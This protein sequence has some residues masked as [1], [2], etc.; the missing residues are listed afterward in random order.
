[1]PLLL[2]VSAA[3]VAALAASA[4]PQTSTVS[5]PVF[6]TATRLIQVSVVVHD[7]RKQ[8][9]SGLRAEDFQIFEDGKEQSVAFFM[10]NTKSTPTMAAEKGLFTNRVQSPS[11]GGVVAIVYDQLNTAQ[12]DQERVRE[13]LIK[14]LAKVNPDD[15][16]GLYVLNSNGL[17]ILH[18]FTRDARSLLRILGGVQNPSSVARDAANEPGA[19]IVGFGDAIDRQLEAFVRTGEANM[20]GFFQRQLALRSIDAMEA[21][22]THLAGVP[23]R[24]NLIW[25]SSGFPFQFRAYGPGTAV[26][27][28]SH[29][30]ARAARALNDADVAV[31]GVDARGLVGAFASPPG[32]RQ[33]TFTTMGTVLGPIEGLR[34][35]AQLTGGEAYFNS[36]DLG[37]AI[38]RAVDDSRLTY[39][40]GYYSEHARWDGRFRGISVKV[41]RNGV[42]V[43]HRAGYYAIPPGSIDK[44]PPRTAAIEDALGSPLETTGLSISVSAQS[45][46]AGRVTLAIQF[47]PGTPL[48]EPRGK[49]W[50]GAVDIAIA[51]SLPTRKQTADTDVTIPLA[52]DDATREQLLKE[53]LRLTR[54]ITLLDDAHDVRVVAR[55]ASTGATGSVIIPATALRQPRP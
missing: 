26:E 21:V 50:H 8:P 20:R 33:Q 48:L 38:A 22:A 15:R 5:Q 54:T 45:A 41:R 27:T 46:G 16:I 36:N 12:L 1:M 39:T 49:T 51:Q 14:F 13:H 47:E 37:A 55:D 53:G 7:G 4:A 28:M 52:L 10:A 24:K 18:D 19:D 29:E 34:Q 31:Y 17:A 23:G 43:R 32:A 11:G 9:V 42:D 35:F 40:L 6:R 25:V 44:L 2:V 3:L 30:T